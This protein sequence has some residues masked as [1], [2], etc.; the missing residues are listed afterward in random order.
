MNDL[1]LI[2]PAKNE[3][4][5]LPMVIEQIKNFDCKINVTLKKDDLETIESIKK[6]HNVNI[7]YQSG[8]GYGNALKEAIISCQTKYFC[9]FNADGSFNPKDLE[10][11][12]DLMESNDFVYTT[13]YENP[14][15]SDDDTYVTYLG[16]KIFSKLGNFFFSLSLS[17]ILYTY[18]MG[19]TESFKKLN[20]T[21]NDFRFCVELP[22]KM[23]ISE[24][25]YKC[26][27]SYENKRIAGR[28][29]VKAFKDGLLILIEMVKLFLIFKLFRK[30]IISK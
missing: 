20:I 4:E 28:K 30:K 7:F 17:D 13:R 1:T 26:I 23:Q 11:M 29:K 5:C 10:A 25:N 21:A 2:I 12:Y 18:I 15:G 6:N 9:I 16:N 19:R 3:K 8:N 27:P 22:I 24:M 14:G